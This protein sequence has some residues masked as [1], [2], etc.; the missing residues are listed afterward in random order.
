MDEIMDTY[1]DDLLADTTTLSLG[2]FSFG[3][4]ALPTRTADL[5]EYLR[6][7]GA[8][9]P[10][11][12][13]AA[14]AAVAPAGHGSPQMERLG[15]D[16]YGHLR[17]IG[18]LPLPPATAGIATS[19]GVAVPG[20]PAV[21][22]DSLLLNT[23]Y[24]QLAVQAPSRLP[25]PPGFPPLS[26]P[27]RAEPVYTTPVGEEHKLRTFMGIP[28]WSN[29]V[30]PRLPPR[31][32]PTVPVSDDSATSRPQL[33]APYDNDIDDSL[34]ITEK[35]PGQRPSPDYL[36]TV[37]RD[38]ISASTRAN[39]VAWMDRFTQ[40]YD[41]A[42]GTLHRS[43][44]YIDRFLSVRVLASYTDH[45]NLLRLLGATAVFT[46]AKYESQ[47]TTRKLNATEVARYGG[48]TEGKEAITRTE[49]V[50]IKALD[51]RLGGP[52]AET[53]V[54]HFT[55]Y[56]QGQKE[57]EVQRLA[58]DIADKSLR[59]YGCL[60]YLPSVVAAASIFRARC[61]LNPPDQLRW[62]AWSTELEEL[63]GY[64]LQHFGSCVCTMMNS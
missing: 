41:L 51:Y 22:D 40:D 1:A 34:R 60:G 57:L 21:Y 15:F 29:A 42:A 9:P 10:R 14:T 32:A 16:A 24:M 33:C 35:E 6:S 64:G 62:T 48:F 31:P 17:A 8:L 5:D 55:R 38:Q 54:D 53:F 26:A 43:V 44:S 12:A 46:A 50:M 45:H 13:A 39:L 37:H 59:N 58:H 19:H 11:P 28:A 18:A 61:A 36:K 3:G 30:Q 56:S 2:T 20:L 63:T 4:G 52:T 7:I 23:S 25:P 47:S 27:A 49:S